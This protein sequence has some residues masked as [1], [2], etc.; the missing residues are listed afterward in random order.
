MGTKFSLIRTTLLLTCVIFSSYSAHH[1]ATLPRP[2]MK[3]RQA[4]TLERARDLHT[5]RLC[6][7]KPLLIKGQQIWLPCMLTSSH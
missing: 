3:L 4:S 2:Q 1:A 5:T 7:A 6:K